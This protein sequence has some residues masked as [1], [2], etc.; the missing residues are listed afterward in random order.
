MI[1]STVCTKSALHYPNKKEVI[2][3]NRPG[4]ERLDEFFRNNYEECCKL[5]RKYRYDFIYLPYLY[6]PERIHSMIKY[7]AP[8]LTEDEVEQYAQN[9]SIK[10]VYD[11]F[12][13]GGESVVWKRAESIFSNTL[14]EYFPIYNCWDKSNMAGLLMSVASV[15]PDSPYDVSDSDFDLKTRSTFL[16]TTLEP[17][18]DEG[19]FDQLD[20]FFHFFE[21]YLYEKFQSSGDIV[22]SSIM[23]NENKLYTN[24]DEDYPTEAYEIRDEIYGKIATLRSMGISEVAIKSLIF[25]AVKPS[26]LRITAD[27]RLFLSD[28]GDKEIQLYPLPKAVFLLY[29]RHPE[30]IMFKHLCEYED[31]L[32][33]I[34]CQLM[35]SDPTEEMKE[36]IKQIV[37][38]LNNSINEKCS[39][40]REAFISVMDTSVANEYYITGARATPK[41]ITLDRNLV[42]FEGESEEA[43]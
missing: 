20:E 33:S 43:K 19:I 21:P 23:C 41:R 6:T 30:G 4:Y 17:E 37:N 38:P 31:E 26:R 34:Y 28:Y 11:Q 14:Y 18:T 42:E 27:Y 16:L 35:D 32:M 36:S 5:F 10:S 1:L 3:I 24:A 9:F 2:F 39:R 29:L 22:C 8:N 40:I 25:P 13:S 7:H 15:R 12:V